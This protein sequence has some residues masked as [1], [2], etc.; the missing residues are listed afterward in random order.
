ML[1]EAMLEYEQD[2]YKAAFAYLVRQEVRTLDEVQLWS[3]TLTHYAKAQLYAQ[4]AITRI[5]DLCVHSEGILAVTV[6]DV[7]DKVDILNDRA[8]ELTGTVNGLSKEVDGLRASLASVTNE[9]ASL[10]NMI[11]QIQNVVAQLPTL[12]VLALTG[13]AIAVIVVVLVY[14]R[15]MTW[16]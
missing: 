10:K 3:E 14:R 7:K 15:T 1:D 9:V 2:M 5:K 6:N 4:M 11:Q 16:K 8:N 13:I 12:Y